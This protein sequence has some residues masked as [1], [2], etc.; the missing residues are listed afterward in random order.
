M[1]LRPAC[2]LGQFHTISSDI[3]QWS[4]VESFLAKESITQNGQD[5]DAN[6]NTLLV[7]QAIASHDF[8]GA[9]GSFV[10]YPTYD[11]SLTTITFENGT[12]YTLANLASTSANFSGVNTGQDFFQRFCNG[13]TTA[14]DAAPDPTT[15]P[16]EPS[17]V[18]SPTGYPSPVSVN[19]DL[20]VGGYFMD[21]IECNVTGV[22]VLSIPTFNLDSEPDDGSLLYQ[23]SD[24]VTSFLQDATASGK[25]Y[26]IVDLRSNPGGT[27][28]ARS[29]H[30]PASLS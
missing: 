18:P 22:A 15:I 6:Y 3:H 24:T 2:C 9:G 11:G 27:S 5:P 30:V 7:N 26:L 16:A 29:R 25:E 14:F 17:S 19:P 1:L 20:S 13:P 12:T 21:D 23:F 4:N 10:G 8:N 28:S